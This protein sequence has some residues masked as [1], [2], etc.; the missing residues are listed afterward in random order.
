MVAHTRLN[1]D[2]IEESFTDCF[3]KPGVV[4][5]VL[6]Q[7]RKG[8]AYCLKSRVHLSLIKGPTNWSVRFS[9]DKH[10]ERE[11]WNLMADF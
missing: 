6:I 5:A 3:I 11:I 4:P 10:S 2:A 8:I 7:V 9:I 1:D